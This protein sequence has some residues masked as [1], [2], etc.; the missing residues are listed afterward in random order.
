MLLNTICH[1]GA[2]GLNDAVVISGRKLA[3][4]IRQEARHE[5]EQWVA[6]GNKRPHLSV[7]LVGE[8]PASHSYVLNKTKAAADV[9]ISSETIL[10]PA[11]ITE[12]ELLDLISKLNNDANV[13]GLLVQLPLPATPSQLPVGV[14]LLGVTEIS[15]CV[16]SIRFQSQK[17]ELGDDTEAA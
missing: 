14:K 10:R 7:V 8:N 15:S 9:G 16:G 4:Q 13:D 5:V 12:E 3:R 11:S 1:E 2:I 6:A 17:L